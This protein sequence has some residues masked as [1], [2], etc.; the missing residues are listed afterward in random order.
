MYVRKKIEISSQNAIY[1]RAGGGC[2]PPLI[3]VPSA[4]DKFG[5]WCAH[6][7]ASRGIN[8]RQ[9]IDESSRMRDRG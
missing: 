6:R 8:R 9:R 2:A 7:S 5:D 1:I 3:C 4:D